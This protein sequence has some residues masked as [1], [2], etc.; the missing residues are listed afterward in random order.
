MINVKT[1][2]INGTNSH[3]YNNS[4]S[5]FELTNTNVI[6]DGNM[7]FEENRGV[8]GAVF[9]LYGT[10]TFHLNNG[11]RATF[12]NNIA[13]TKGGAIYA[14]DDI[15]KTIKQCTFQI[16]FSFQN[17]T[18]LNISMIFINNTAGLSGSSIYSTNLY[19]CYGQ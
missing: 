6:L 16:S 4:G 9:K 2:Y 3:Y 5:V 19:N 1:L 10:S 18:G 17:M 7:W 14:Q 12:I 13:H 11:L 8:R 15:Y